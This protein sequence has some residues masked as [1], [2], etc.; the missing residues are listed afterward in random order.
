MRNDEFEFFLLMFNLFKENRRQFDYNLKKA[1]GD[2]Y[3]HRLLLAYRHF[4][5]NQY[6][7]ALELLKINS[8]LSKEFEAIRSYL[9]G[10]VL[11]QNCVYAFAK[12]HLERS[13][14]ILTGMRDEAFI[15]KP[16][17]VLALAQASTQDKKGFS[18]SIKKI[19]CY[20]TED[21]NTQ[22]QLAQV[23][24]IDF[25]LLN[26]LD[27]CLGV[28][29][30]VF[31]Q[32]EKEVTPHLS[33]FLTIKFMV[34][35]KE[36]NFIECY[37]TLQL[38]KQSSGASVRSNYT[39]MKILLNHY[40][41]DETIYLY[42]SDYLR[43][44]ELLHQLQVIKALSVGDVESARN[45]W[46]LL[47]R[48]NSGLYLDE[49]V[50]AGDKNL[51]SLCLQ[52]HSKVAHRRRTSLSINEDLSALERLHHILNQAQVPLL[53][54]ELISMLWKDAEYCPKLESRFHKLIS[55]YRQKYSAKIRIQQGYYS[56]ADHAA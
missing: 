3:K 49:F 39:F 50:Y 21:R 36:D 35:V 45:F 28:I 1:S 54:D 14:T 30:N 51:F 26:R 2:I 47:R 12:E 33:F 7:H 5:L 17:I 20:T 6:E 8:S 55:R 53:K 40:T 29:Q 42:E 24:A 43:S 9:L 4:Q 52:K 19:S 56:L 46:S 10:M 23:R 27:E 38:Y 13:I 25:L 34:H 44:P 16:L 15:L 32:Y 37:R 41:K 22:V 11:N 31:E 18:R 48:H